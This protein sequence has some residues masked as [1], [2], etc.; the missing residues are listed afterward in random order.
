MAESPG[1]RNRPPRRNTQASLSQPSP[2]V[3]SKGAA[4]R[5][6]IADRLGQ[7]PPPSP[8]RGWRGDEVESSAMSSSTTFG[9][10]SASVL[11]LGAAGPRGPG[12]CVRDR[13]RAGS[14]RRR[15]KASAELA[16]QRRGHVSPPRRRARPACRRCASRRRAP[17]A[18]AARP[19]TIC[20][21]RG[22]PCRP[23]R[24]GA[25]SR[26][27]QGLGDRRAWSGRRRRCS[28]PAASAF[29]TAT[30]V[31]SPPMGQADVAGDCRSAST[32]SPVFS[33]ASQPSSSNGRVIR[34]GWATRRDGH[35]EGEVGV[36]RAHDR[37]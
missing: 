16:S 13:R 31:G 29:S 35:L 25:C 1:T 21:G 3:E 28:T 17:S 22:G 20:P 2:S 5:Q 19:D 32:P 26:R 15:M 11:D 18:A 6:D 9:G 4:E 10:R 24:S 37:R 34:V 23:A 30:K 36:G 33:S 14:A 7:A 12:R 27:E 8:G